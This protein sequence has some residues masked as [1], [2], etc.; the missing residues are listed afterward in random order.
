MVGIH[1]RDVSPNRIINDANEIGTHLSIKVE[2]S[3]L[4]AMVWNNLQLGSRATAHFGRSDDDTVFTGKYLHR[5][6]YLS[7]VGIQRMVSF[8][9]GKHHGISQGR[10]LAINQDGIRLH[11]LTRNDSNPECVKVTDRPELMRKHISHSVRR[12]RHM[13]SFL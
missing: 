2:M 10:N 6:D 12:G 7:K 13:E 5:I 8:E 4:V 11:A 3:E 9:V 1:K